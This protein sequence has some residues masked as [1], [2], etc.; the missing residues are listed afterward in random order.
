[1]RSLLSHGG[2]FTLENSTSTPLS[3]LPPLDIASTGGNIEWK[4]IKLFDITYLTVNDKL[5]G[6]EVQEFVLQLRR[7]LDDP[8][9]PDRGRFEMEILL[10][11]VIRELLAQFF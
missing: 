1:M 3:V 5:E 11:S 10:D 8:E 6:W 4:A 7:L 2:T 9:M